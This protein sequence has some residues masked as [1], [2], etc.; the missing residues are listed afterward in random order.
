MLNFSFVFGQE[1][2]QRSLSTGSALAVSTYPIW[3]V[4][5][6]AGFLANAAYC[7]YLLRK[8]R[9]W[10]VYWTSAAPGGY[11]LGAA[12][13]GILWFG[14]IAAYGMGANALGGLGGVV[15]W[16]VF[17]AMNIIT[18]NVWGAVTGEWAGVSRGSY[19]YSWAGICA[20]LVA[21]FV[22]SRGGA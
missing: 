15:G 6:S 1:L 16:P 21:I 17:V 19:A 20:L 11:W 18:G 22:I 3:S 14:G 13:M 9:S 5:L 4:A 7:F 2:Q 8:N 12:L 10:P